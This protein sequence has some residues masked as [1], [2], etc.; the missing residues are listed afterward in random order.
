VASGLRSRRQQPPADGVQPQAVQANVAV[1]SG[2]GGEIARTLFLTVPGVLVLC[3]GG[4]LLAVV[5]AVRRSRAGRPLPAPAAQAGTWAQG[6]APA[7]WFADPGRR[8][9]LRYW[10]GQ[11]WTEHV[12]DRGTQAVDPL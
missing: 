9:Q 10:D 8:H 3:L 2:T 4:V 12:S 11:R 5:V 6:A 7:G 1:G